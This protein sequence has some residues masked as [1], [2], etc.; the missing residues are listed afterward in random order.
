MVWAAQPPPAV[1]TGAPGAADLTSGT[2][3][4]SLTTYGTT[5]SYYFQYGTTRAYG[6]RTPPQPAS[7]GDAPIPV[8]GAL[9]NLNPATSYH[10]RLV[11]VNSAGTTRGADRTFT[12]AGYY[13]NAVYTAAAIPDP[14]VLDDGDAHSDY[15]A[16]A[17]G[18]LF[19]VLHSSDLVHWTAQG[20][21]MSGRPKWVTKAPDWHPWAPSVVQTAQACPGTTSSSCY[22][23]YYVALSASLNVNCIG[24]A[25]SPTPGGPYRD[26][27][28]L[29]DDPSIS[30]DTSSSTPPIGCSDDYGKGN[31]DPSPFIDPSGQAYLYVSTDRTCNGT[32]CVLKP[33]LSVIP[34]SSDLEHASGARQPLLSGDPGTWEAAGV[35]V[36]TVEGPSVELHNGIYYLFYSGGSWRGAYGSGYATGLSPTGPFTKA[37]SNP[38]LAMSS[39]VRTPGGGDDLVT[40]PHQSQWLVYAGRDQTYTAPRMLRLDR[41]GWRP[42]PGGP[43]TP[44][45]AGPTTTPQPAQP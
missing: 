21:A 31:I 39:T 23:M 17:T 40:G 38:V 14:Y 29:A 5:T 41:F 15:W 4:G 35:Q 13:Q 16:F 27:G 7:G 18:N 37:P 10:Y 34:L 8:S 20:T 9:G 28:P 11:A 2:V 33:T 32:S 3:T 1:Q 43:D 26:Q 30:T 42:V 36:P 19:P 24:V 25:T 45:I 44:V 6:A 22:V 12:T